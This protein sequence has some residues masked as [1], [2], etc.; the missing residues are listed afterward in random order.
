MNWVEVKAWPKLVVTAHDSDDDD[1]QGM[2][3]LAQGVSAVP[4]PEQGGHLVRTLNHK[5][6]VTI[7]AIVEKSP[8]KFLSMNGLNEINGEKGSLRAVFQ[9]PDFFQG[10]FWMGLAACH[11]RVHQK[12]QD[13]EYL[14]CIALLHLQLRIICAK[15]EPARRFGIPRLYRRTYKTTAVVSG[16]EYRMYLTAVDKGCHAYH[17]D[18]IVVVRQSQRRGGLVTHQCPKFVL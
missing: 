17:S 2:G 5:S 8:P 12:L 11:R 6:I 10:R 9:I 1:G 3:L 14:G 16:D 15:W 7:N 4:T 18:H 13:G